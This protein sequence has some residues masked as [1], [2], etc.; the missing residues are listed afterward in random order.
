M[1]DDDAGSVGGAAHIAALL[2]VW[3]Q[4]RCTLECVL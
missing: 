3:K 2:P 1:T 4:Q